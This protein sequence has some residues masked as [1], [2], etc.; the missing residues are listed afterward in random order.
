MN[1][2]D[3]FGKIGIFSPAFWAAPN[4]VNG[5]LTTTPKL[6]LRL[7]MD[8]GTNENSASQTDSAVYWNGAL[9]I[10]NRWLGLGYAVNR[11]QLFYPERGAIHN[12]SAWSRRLPVFYRF[13]LNP[14]DE[15]NPLALAK[16]P[17][18]LTLQIQ[19]PNTSHLEFLAPLAIRFGVEK[20][21]DLQSWSAPT[22]LAP[23][24]SIWEQRTVDEPLPPASPATFWRLR[25]GL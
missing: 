8:I 14:W 25:Y 21:S 17:P 20:S 4:F 12:E 23:A 22:N 15:P 9:A 13:I 7:Y 24:T 6:P 19:S 3:T 10:Y 16:F 5:S 11:D 1:R 18:Q 2:S